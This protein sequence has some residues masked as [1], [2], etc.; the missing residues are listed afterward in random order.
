MIVWLFVS[1]GESFELEAP[2]KS[3]LEC[4]ALPREADRFAFWRGRT[5][6]GRIRGHSMVWQT[7]QATQKKG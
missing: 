4:Y 5:G 6:E 1:S 2:D 7:C 3:D